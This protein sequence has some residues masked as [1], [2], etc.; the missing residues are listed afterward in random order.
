MVVGWVVGTDLVDVSR[1]LGRGESAQTTVQYATQPR[2][3][4]STTR[5]VHPALTSGRWLMWLCCGYGHACLLGS[6]DC[7]EAADLGLDSR[8]KL[9][10]PP[11]LP[12][13]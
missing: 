8:R 10:P 9:P 13:S 4:S 12:A 7:D 2:R 1:R 3:S 5:I 6:N 11:A